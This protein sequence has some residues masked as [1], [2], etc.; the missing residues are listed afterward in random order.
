MKLD[1]ATILAM[2]QEDKSLKKEVLTSVLLIV[3]LIAVV[4]FSHQQKVIQTTRANAEREQRKEI[5]QKLEH[6]RQ[7]ERNL[8]NKIN[9][10]TPRP[11]RAD[12]IDE[13]QKEILAKMKKDGLDVQTLNRLI[14]AIDPKQ[15][16][17]A[18][19][20]PGIKKQEHPDFEA[21]VVGSW[22][23]TVKNLYE[24]E[25]Q[26]FLVNVRS[27]K[28]EAQSTG[29]GMRTTFRYRVYVL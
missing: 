13:V 22:E 18:D 4:V 11:I 27:V 17:A 5:S 3:V 7:N 8:Q 14:P 12:Q 23:A 21:T 15:K 9:G 26:S 10:Q 16:Q 19:K 20:K 1:R 2:M 28:M 25:R 24:M 6:Y 29:A